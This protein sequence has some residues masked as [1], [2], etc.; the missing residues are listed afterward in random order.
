MQAFLDIFMIVYNFMKD[1]IILSVSI[2]GHEVTF[3][4]LNV[5][6]GTTVISIGI[7]VLHKIFD[8]E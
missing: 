5:L 3:T 1:T 8:W 6:I 7:T 2:G 4:F